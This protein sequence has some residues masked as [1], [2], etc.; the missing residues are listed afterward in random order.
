MGVDPSAFIW[1][2]A[3]NGT[4]EGNLKAADE[5]VWISLD[6][7]RTRPDLEPGALYSVGWYADRILELKKNG[8]LDKVLI[9][10]DSGWYDPAKPGGGTFTG[11]TDIFN[12][13]LPVLK[14]KGFSNADIDQ[15]MVKNPRE[16]F[17]I[18]IRKL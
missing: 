9:S 17:K 3:Q 15:I 4:I 10:H 16:A 18:K 14:T 1:V 13:L 12:S 11:F 2:H 7:V 8:F 5:G 6:N